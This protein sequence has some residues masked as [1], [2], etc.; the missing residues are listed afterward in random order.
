MLSDGRK[1]GFG[2]Q[3]YANGNVF[4][5]AFSDVRLSPHALAPSPFRSSLSDCISHRRPKL[6]LLAT[7]PGNFDGG[8]CEGFGIWRY[9]ATDAEKK[10]G[11]SHINVY[12]VQL[13]LQ[14]SA[15]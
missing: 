13:P 11:A 10:S 7:L 8:S 2:T 15:R 3:T 1:H 14:P 5:G 6:L 12:K 9:W 4:E